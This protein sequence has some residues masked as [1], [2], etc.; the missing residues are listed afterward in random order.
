MN[1]RKPRWWVRTEGLWPIVLRRAR[2]KQTIWVW[3]DLA[4]ARRVVKGLNR[5]ERKHD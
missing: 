1:E 3:G 2:R 5:K 4:L